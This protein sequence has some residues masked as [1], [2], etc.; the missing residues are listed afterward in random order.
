[1]SEKKQ[2]N[3]GIS[4]G[5]EFFAH[6]MSVNFSP[7]QFILDFRCITPRVDSRTRDGP[8][9]ALKHNV[10]L[11]DPWHAKE[12]LRVIDNVI[13]RYEQEFGK[14]TKPKA[15]QKYEKKAKKLH[16]EGAQETQAPSYMG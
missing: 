4:D 2:I 15:V 16:K 6:E 9:V 10:V 12:M 7:T 8:F 13:Q 14:I 3:M 5:N 1:M 11:V